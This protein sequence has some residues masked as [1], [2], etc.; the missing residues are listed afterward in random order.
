VHADDGSLAVRLDFDKRYVALAPHATLILLVFKLQDPDH[1]LGSIPVSGITMALVD[2]HAP[3]VQ[4]A[5]HELQAGWR[6][7]EHCDRYH[8][9]N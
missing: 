3:G 9:Y 1:L 8:P 2:A 6:Q 4:R 5:R 7:Y